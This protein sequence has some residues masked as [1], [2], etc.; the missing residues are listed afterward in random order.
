[1]TPKLPVISG[2]DLIKAFSKFGY[3]AVRQ[4]GSHVRMRHP[5]DAQQQPVTV[6]QH[7]TLKR[8]LLCR[9]LREARISV[10]QLTE[11]L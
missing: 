1:M 11:V 10:D 9:T 2:E 5:T 7:K 8:G 4:Q 3:V 6:P